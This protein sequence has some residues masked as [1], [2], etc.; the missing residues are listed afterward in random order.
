MGERIVWLKEGFPHF[1]DEVENGKFKKVKAFR[2]WTNPGDSEYEYDWNESLIVGHDIVET[3]NRNISVLVKCNKDW[4]AGKVL[5]SILNECQKLAEVSKHDFVSIEPFGDKLG[6]LIS[7]DG[8]S[9]LI[10][11]KPRLFKIVEKE[12]DS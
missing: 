3:P 12:G 7:T 2:Y 8:N 4:D 9:K 10:E 1:L 5:F 11:I 6:K